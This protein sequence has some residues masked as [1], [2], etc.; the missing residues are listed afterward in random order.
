MLAAS[1]PSETHVQ[2]PN[3]PEILPPLSPATYELQTKFR[4]GGPIRSIY[5][6]G[7]DLLRDI[8]EI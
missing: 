6:L 4:L 2:E 7:G 8:V 1:T 3:E 5:G